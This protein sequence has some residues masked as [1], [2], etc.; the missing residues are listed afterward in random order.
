MLFLR[1]GLD[2]IGVRTCREY[3]GPLEVLR[4]HYLYAG[5]P[6]LDGV[7]YLESG[8]GLG[9]AMSALMRVP[10]DRRPWFKAEALQRLAESSYSQQRKYLLAECVDKYLPLAD[11]EQEEFD[12]LLEENYQEAKTMTAPTIYEEGMRA[13]VTNLL[14][15]QLEQKFGPLSE[16]VLHRIEEMSADEMRN[17]AKQILAA[18]SLS[19]LGLNT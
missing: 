2:G 8:S 17:I 10:S 12:Q 5:L 11:P 15:L 13:G 18:S 7:E 1:V 19:D 14:M 6:A 16:S 4:F 3:F 9:I